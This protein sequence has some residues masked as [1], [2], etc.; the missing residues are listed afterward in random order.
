VLL[1]SIV[2]PSPAPPA[3]ACGGWGEWGKNYRKRGV[4]GYDVHKH[5]KGRKRHL[6]V[7]T[8]GL[9]IAVV[10]SAASVQDRDGAK[11]VIEKI[12][13]S[14][15]RLCLIWADGA[16]AGKLIDWVLEKCGWKLYCARE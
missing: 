9:I 11:L 5:V 12:K 8:M 10:V 13:D 2:T 16:Y 3:P 15:Q 4:K 1:L 14:I 7:D 6:L